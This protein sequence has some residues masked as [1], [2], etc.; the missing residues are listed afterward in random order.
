MG[1]EVARYRRITKKDQVYSSYESA[2]RSRSSIDSSIALH[3]ESNW[4]LTGRPQALRM[5]GVCK[6]RIREARWR[7]TW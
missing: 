1:N 6:L 2:A 7:T 5:K 3:C 4:M